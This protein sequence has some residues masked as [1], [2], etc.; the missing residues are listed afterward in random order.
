VGFNV[1]VLVKRK[2]RKFR[3]DMSVVICGSIPKSVGRNG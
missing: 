3:A 2:T 1:S